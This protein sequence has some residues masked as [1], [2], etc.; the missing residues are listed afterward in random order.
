MC[1]ISWYANVAKLTSVKNE[2]HPIFHANVSTT[3]ALKLKMRINIK[4]QNTSTWTIPT[5]PSHWSI[6]KKCL[7]NPNGL[8]GE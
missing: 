3:I 8:K 7:W 5:M 2:Q 4:S 1:N 6:Q